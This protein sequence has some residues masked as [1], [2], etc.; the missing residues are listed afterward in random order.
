M[1]R[2]AFLIKTARGALVDET[3][4]CDALDEGQL[5]GAGLDVYEDEPNV[6][7]RLLAMPNVVLAPHI[8]SATEETRSAMARIAATDVAMFLRGQ[9]PLHVIV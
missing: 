8:G 4:L 6:S 2:G 5:G 7:S 9:R 1:K 3:A